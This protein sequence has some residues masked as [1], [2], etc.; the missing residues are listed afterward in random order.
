MRLFSL[1]TSF[2]KWFSIL[3]IIFAAVIFLG[4]HA[5]IAFKWFPLG[6]TPFDVRSTPKFWLLIAPGPAAALASVLLERWIGT[7]GEPGSEVRD[8]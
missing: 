2:L 5:M 7:K 8:D 6:L 1:L 4:S 3:W